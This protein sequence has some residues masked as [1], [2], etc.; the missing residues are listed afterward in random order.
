M[1]KD[2]IKG[3]HSIIEKDSRTSDT[4]QPITC[5]GKGILPTKH[6]PQAG[7][8]QPYDI[9]NAIGLIEFDLPHLELRLV[10]DEKIVVGNI[11]PTNW[12]S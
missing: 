3:T 8:R 10:E 5:Q 4:R 7:T 6:P 1:G 11:P 2:P 12:V 9:D